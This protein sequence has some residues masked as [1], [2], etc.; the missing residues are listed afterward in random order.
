MYFHL[1]VEKNEMVEKW[2]MC[3]FKMTDYIGKNDLLGKTD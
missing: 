2:P 3:K 1:R